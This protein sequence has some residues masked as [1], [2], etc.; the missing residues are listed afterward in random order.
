LDLR[1]QGEKGYLILQGIGPNRIFSFE[2]GP[3]SVF[4]GDKCIFKTRGKNKMGWNDG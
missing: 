3:Y 1:K 2:R 4:S